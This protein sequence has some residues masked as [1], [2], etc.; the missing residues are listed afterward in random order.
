MRSQVQLLLTGWAG[1]QKFT[2][3][4]ID[5]ILN[6]VL[7]DKNYLAMQQKVSGFMKYNGSD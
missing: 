6:L 7:P 4:Q 1:Q 5:L 3:I 2:A